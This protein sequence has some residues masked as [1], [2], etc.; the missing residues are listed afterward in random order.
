RGGKALQVKP[1]GSTIAMPDA[2]D[3]DRTQ[4]F[5]ASAWVKLTRRGS[6]G[7]VVARMDPK[8]KHR[9][10]DLWVEGDKPGTHIIS[11]FPED[12]LKVVGNN[13]LPFNQ[14]AHVAIVYDGSAKPSGVT[15]YLNGVP[16]PT[17]T[18]FDTLKS[19]T[20]TEVP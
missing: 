18:Q 20:R 4:P 1:T 19:T 17:T 2:G 6:T 14:W 8:N 15:V 3:F 13:P 16:Q 12:A 7:A 5:T 10:W 9:G 11:A